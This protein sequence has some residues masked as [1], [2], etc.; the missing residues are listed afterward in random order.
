MINCNNRFCIQY[1]EWNKDKCNKI[2]C[3]QRDYFNK[4]L[5]SM[6]KWNKETPEKLADYLNIL[7]SYYPEKKD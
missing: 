2:E 4:I 3:H 6:I 7:K 5:D 1:D